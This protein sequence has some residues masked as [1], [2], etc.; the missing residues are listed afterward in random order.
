MTKHKVMDKLEMRI[1]IRRPSGW[2]AESRSHTWRMEVGMADSWRVGEEG[3]CG[4]RTADAIRTF[5]VYSKLYPSTLYV[6]IVNSTLQPYSIV[7]S[8]VS[9]AVCDNLEIYNKRKNLKH[10]KSDEGLS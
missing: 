8:T 1:M 10:L 2:W 5:L 3:G 7:I 9:H 6:C 4:V